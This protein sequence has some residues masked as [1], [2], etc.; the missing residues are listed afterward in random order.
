[1]AAQRPTE[2]G[3]GALEKKVSGRELAA[4]SRKQALKIIFN[5]AD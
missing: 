2:A 4:Y 3:G 5:I 1:V